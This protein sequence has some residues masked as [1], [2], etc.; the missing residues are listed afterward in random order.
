MAQFQFSLEKVLR[1][2]GIELTRQEAVL[3]RVLQQHR[4]L[5]AAA[6]SV[7]GERSQLTSSLGHLVDL[8]GSDLRASAAYSLRL[9]QKAEKIAQLVAR[10]ARDLAAQQKKYSEAQLR[11][12]LLEELK[13]RQVQRWEYEEARQLETLAAESHLA[14]WNRKEG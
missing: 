2:R 9:R 8:Q 13:T 12:R 3:Q 4:R 1:W 11:V 10:S 5:E 7:A 6:Q 14:S